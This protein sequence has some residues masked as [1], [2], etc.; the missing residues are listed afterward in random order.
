V[1][2]SV[3]CISHL[4]RQAASNGASRMSRLITRF[5]LPR[6]ERYERW[7]LDQ[8][9]RVVVTSPHEAAALRRLNP[10]AP[11]I[12]VVPNGV[13][14]AYFTHDESATRNPSAIVLTGKMSYHVNVSMA[15]HFVR[16]ILPLVWNS[17]S[18]AR[19]WIAGQDPP[20]EIRS[21]A[22]HPQITVTGSVPDLRPYL[23]SAAVAVAP[24]SYAAGVQNKVLEA[25]AC[26]TPVVASPQAVAALGARHGRE[27]LVCGD[28]RSFADGV[29]ALLN[30]QGIRRALG[31][32]GRKY[33]EKHHRWNDS[34]N[35]LEDMYRELIRV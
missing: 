20:R 17:R 19:L 31:R 30:D 28:T 27:L 29:I 16:D 24:A 34:V 33:V 11:E 4:F 13:D 23:R 25:M 22:Q 1:W 35:K 10:R 21:L 15:L 3:D 8:F 18:D 5:E 7:L 14:L 6:T 26:G 9:D 12:S 32:A 2:D